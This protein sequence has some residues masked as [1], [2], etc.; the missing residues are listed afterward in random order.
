MRYGRRF[1]LPIDPWPQASLAE[2]TAVGLVLTALLLV[3]ACAAG[4]LMIALAALG[5]HIAWS[6]AFGAALR[7][8]IARRSGAWRVR[9]TRK[10]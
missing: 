2:R 9:A 6:Y 8:G 7:D 10:A 1:S 5:S 3:P 4:A